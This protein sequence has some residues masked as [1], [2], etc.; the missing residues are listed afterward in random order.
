ML[1]IGTVKTILTKKAMDKSAS[2]ADRISQK[3]NQ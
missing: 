3:E 2:S 1:F